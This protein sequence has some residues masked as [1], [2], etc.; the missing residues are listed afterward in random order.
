MKALKLLSLSLLFSGLL[1]GCVIAVHD[2][3]GHYSS[4][5]WK[6]RQEANRKEI[7]NLRT[8]M[9]MQQ[10]TEKLG[11]AD[12]SEGFER[13]GKNYVILYYRTRHVKSD[14]ETSRE[15]TTPLVFEEGK[16]KGWGNM[17]LDE[18]R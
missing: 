2:G 15:E 8:G 11:G 18:V 10:I 16:L 3:E 4:D 7:A 5:E 1:S 12:D 14:G 6:E 17:A 13:N 9:D